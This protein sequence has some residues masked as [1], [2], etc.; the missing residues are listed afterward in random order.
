MLLTCL[1]W[2]VYLNKK[3]VYYYTY[4]QKI[5]FYFCWKKRAELDVAES[6]IGGGKKPARISARWEWQRKKNLCCLYTGLH[7]FWQKI[8]EFL[9]VESSFH[10]SLRAVWIVSTCTFFPF[11]F[12]FT[13]WNRRLVSRQ[14][15]HSVELS[16]AFLF[17]T[18]FVKCPLKK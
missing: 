10:F 2:K 4:A 1:M 13:A 14:T 17:L 7:Q 12:T 3:R 15:C 16:W 11:A 6:L 8:L 5:C 9:F 18:K